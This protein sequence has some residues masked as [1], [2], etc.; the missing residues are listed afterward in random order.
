MKQFD[1]WKKS[2]KHLTYFNGCKYERRNLEGNGDIGI[3]LERYN[4]NGC[5]YTLRKR[6]DGDSWGHGIRFSTIKEC[7]VHADKY[8]LNKV[9][10]SV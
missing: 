10:E 5:K 2:E 3:F 1:G 8:F 6:P 9:E 7:K 4:V